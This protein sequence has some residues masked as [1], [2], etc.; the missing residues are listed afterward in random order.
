VSIYTVLIALWAS[1]FVLTAADGVGA[2]A[3]IV[4]ATQERASSVRETS[5]SQVEALQKQITALQKQLAEVAKQ[6][7]AQDEKTKK[8]ESIK[9]SK[10]ALKEEP[11]KEEPQ[12]AEVPQFDPGYIAVPGTNAAI[13]FSGMVTL[14]AI[15]DVKTNTSEQSQVQRIPYS[16]TVNQGNDFKW[17]RH[18][19]MH[20]KQSRLG[21]NS[22]VKNKS[23]PDVTAFIEADFFGST[24]WG[25][26][27]S[28]T[29][30]TSPSSPVSTTYTFRLRHAVL[31]YAGLEA[32]HTT[33]TFH[34]TEIG[35]PSVDFNGI[36]G[37]YNRHA[38]VRYTHK[39]G[40]FSLTGAAEHSR[41]D[42]VQYTP[43]VG[44]GG[45]VAGSRFAY[46]AQD[47]G[48][49]LGKPEVPDFILRLKYKFTNS[50]VVSLSGIYR[51][52][53]I[54]N[55]TQ[56]TPV[57]GRAYTANGL[58]LNLAAKIMTFGKSFL[59][60]GVIAGRGIGWYIAEA[61]GRSAFFNVNPTDPSQRVYQPIQMAMYWAGYSQVWN[62]QWQTS[63][64]IA[65]IE[66]ET[67][68]LFNNAINGQGG[69]AL[70]SSDPGVD[71]RFDKFLINTTYKPVDSLELGV[72]F[73]LLQRKSVAGKN[74]NGQ[75]LQFGASYKF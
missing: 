67:Q 54:K 37:G 28:P 18:F 39:M 51:D 59:S 43:S 64:G 44:G 15:Y 60:G 68:T 74:G 71:R 48:S 3:R 47:T 49:S 5:A 16:V 23:G 1:C 41:T 46:F 4:Q 58:G 40:D 17:N 2:N 36:T 8:E 33:T 62:P 13:K 22:I 32:G 30:T 61:N 20:A 24:N 9:E 52:L 27:A 66:L 19:Y 25:D 26:A 55:N 42:Y 14:D 21:I 6:V 11:K 53:R 50:S 57:D 63:V 45:A 7:K 12:K 72:E 31:A 56:G 73:F 75:R 10:V 34:S 35:L 65:R 29:G 70:A 69:G 38:L